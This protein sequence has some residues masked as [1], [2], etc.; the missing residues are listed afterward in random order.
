[1]APESIVFSLLY[2]P[3]RA[4]P[5]GTM[6]P[7]AILIRARKFAFR[8]ANGCGLPWLKMLKMVTPLMLEFVVPARKLGHYAEVD[9][10]HLV[11]PGQRL[12]VC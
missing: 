10:Q 7:L 8:C 1:M 6:P 9:L 3:W 4:R 11:L 12:R 5:T 2:L